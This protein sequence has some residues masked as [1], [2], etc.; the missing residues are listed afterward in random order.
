MGINTSSGMITTYYSTGSVTTGDAGADVGGL[1]GDNDSSITTSYSSGTVNGNASN[2]VG[3]LVGV[4]TN[5]GTITNVITAWG[6][7]TGLAM[8]AGWWGI[9]A[10]RSTTPTAPGLVSGNNTIGGLV[11]SSNTGSINNSF[12]DMNSSGTDVAVGSGSGT[13]SHVFGLDPIDMVNSATYL[14]TNTSS[15]GLVVTVNSDGSSNVPSTHS[16]IDISFS[17]GAWNIGTNLGNTW[18]I[19]N[20]QTR[21]MLSMEY[22]TTITN[23]HQLQLIGLNFGTLGASYTLANDEHRFKR[24][25]TSPSDIWAGGTVGGFLPIGYI[26]DNDS[27]SF[28]GTFNGQGHTINALFLNRPTD[29]QAS[30]FSAISTGATVENVGLTNVQITGSGLVGGLVG[31]NLGGTIRNAYTTGLVSGNFEVGGLVGLNS[32][33]TISNTFSTASIIGNGGSSEVGGLVGENDA[34]I[35][36]SYSTGTVTGNTDVGGLVGYNNSAL[37]TVTGSYATGN[38]GGNMAIGGLVGRNNGGS[39]SIGYAT[40]SVSGNDQVGGLVGYSNGTIEMTSATGPVTGTSNLGGLVGFNEGTVQ[41]SFATGSVSGD[42]ESFNV[43]GLAG[44]NTGTVQTSYATGQVSGSSDVGGLVGNIVGEEDNVGTVATSYWAQDTGLNVGLF[45]VGSSSSNTGATPETLANLNLQGTFTP[46]GTSPSNWDFARVWTTNGDTTT[47]QL[48][49][50]PITLTGTAYTDS[51]F[52]ISPNVG[53]N[54]ISGGNL[55]DPSYADSSGNFFFTTS[56]S[57]LIAGSL[58]TNATN[59]ATIYYQ[60]NIPAN[61]INLE[62]F[63]NTLKVLADTASNTALGNAAGSL[64]GVGINYT[65]SGANLTTNLLGVQ[66][67][68]SWMVLCRTAFPSTTGRWTAT[69]PSGRRLRARTRMRSSPAAAQASR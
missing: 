56:S 37:A 22:S 63:G 9:T 39:I 46:A 67:G 28:F 57:N 27:D 58:L 17:P 20:G 62:L 41:T 34:L 55:L 33:G 5:D 47:P 29:S 68:P 7:R 42:D 65:V 3:G 4:N 19:L 52:T 1:V 60:A 59:N 23:G 45:G 66:H 16:G 64:S 13:A 21:P 12:W 36:N 61:T 15:S 18:V 11:G 51:G 25:T 49:I 14:G 40:G 32:S 2:N 44:Q 54:L 6:R 26:D 53:V 38:V 24:G 43:G 31:W 8:W 35:S 10:A 50:Q 30:L 69:S 48:I